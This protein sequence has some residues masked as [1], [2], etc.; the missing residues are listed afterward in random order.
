[1][2]KDEM[3]EEL[4]ATNKKLKNEIKSLESG[5]ELLLKKYEELGVEITKHTSVE[6]SL[7]SPI[8]NCVDYITISHQRIAI[9]RKIIGVE[10]WT[11]TK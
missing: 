2:N 8:T 10:R 4:E 11:K 5:L 7:D 6:H 9:P 3:I 1:M